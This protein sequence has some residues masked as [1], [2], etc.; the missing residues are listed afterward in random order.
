MMQY[1]DKNYCIEQ[2]SSNTYKLYLLDPE[3]GP[4]FKKMI[5]ADIG[6]NVRFKLASAI[7]DNFW[8][9]IESSVGEEN[10]IL[11]VS[12]LHGDDFS[13]ISIPELGDKSI[14]GIAAD[15]ETV[16]ICAAAGFNTESG[17]AVFR[18]RLSDSEIIQEFHTDGLW[19]NSGME[20]KDNRLYIYA[21]SDYQVINMDNSGRM[22]SIYKASPEYRYNLDAKDITV[23]NDDLIVF[24][25]Y[26]GRETLCSI[27]RTTDYLEIIYRPDIPDDVFLDACALDV[28]GNM[29]Y[30]AGP[31]DIKIFENDQFINSISVPTDRNIYDLAVS[32]D[33][34]IAFTAAFNMT[35]IIKNNGIFLIEPPEGE[36]LPLSIAAWGNN[37][38]L[39]RHFS[40]PGGRVFS[41][42]VSSKRI[43][44]VMNFEKESYHSDITADSEG[45]F[46]MN[47]MGS[48]CKYDESGNLL[49][50]KS[51][52]PNIHEITAVY[53]SSAW[54]KLM[55]LVH[56]AIYF[57]NTETL[58]TEKT[59]K[60]WNL[61]PGIN[62]RDFAVSEDGDIYILTY[63]DT[64]YKIQLK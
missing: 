49:L 63:L 43:N 22:V 28:Q 18:I 52:S 23:I 2:I 25:T 62:I 40:T 38:F 13:V 15:S 21:V 33:N 20:L 39:M 42:N 14:H 37:D 6:R 50:D 16:Y 29:L 12:S 53:Y 1:N 58:E 26:E 3:M 48:I 61:I 45:N 34:I 55:V 56:S 24:G 60:T 8:M 10:G 35:G 51:L 11:Y 59:V 57:L 30:V 41:F 7:N 31:T 32:G 36:Y 9:V 47:I 4:V 19:A 64:L 5:T 54:D 46:Y 44:P 17:D 27:D